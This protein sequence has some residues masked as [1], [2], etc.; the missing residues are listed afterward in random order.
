MS[1]PVV[2]G[3]ADKSR[4]PKAAVALAFDA[5]STEIRRADEKVVT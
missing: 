3:N 5:L 1:G 4:D 2:P